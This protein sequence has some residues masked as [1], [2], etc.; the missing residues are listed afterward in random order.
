MNLLVFFDFEPKKCFR[1][2]T[3]WGLYGAEGASRTGMRSAGTCACL[4][5]QQTASPGTD[6]TTPSTMSRGVPACECRA[7]GVCCVS[8]GSG[9]GDANA[10]G[11][12]GRSPWGLICAHGVSRGIDLGKPLKRAFRR[13]TGRG[14]GG[15]RTV[16]FRKLAVAFDGSGVFRPFWSGVRQTAP[17]PHHRVRLGGGGVTRLWGGGGLEV[18]PLF[19]AWEVQRIKFWRRLGRWESCTRARSWE[20]GGGHRC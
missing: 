9:T 14:G 5:A 11:F 19:W 18:P 7:G 3:P 20:N 16:F 10:V 1:V 15:S 4:E 13:C 2:P 17:H 6:H 8:R 12:G